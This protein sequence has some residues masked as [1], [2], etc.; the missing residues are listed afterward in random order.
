MREKGLK[1][2]T[3][4]QIKTLLGEM[5]QHAK[6]LVAR[7]DGLSSDPGPIWEK[8]EKGHHLTS[9]CTLAFSLFLS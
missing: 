1:L 3:S 6:T 7:P 5:A 2:F 9:A 4:G 8:G